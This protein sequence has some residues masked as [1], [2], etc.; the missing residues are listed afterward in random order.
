MLAQSHA[1][2]CRASSRHSTGPASCGAFLLPR[3]PAAFAAAREVLSGLGREGTLAAVL[4]AM[5]TY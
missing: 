3:H 5:S 2:A 1:W 4:E